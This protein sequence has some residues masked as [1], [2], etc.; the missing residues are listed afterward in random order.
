MPTYEYRCLDCGKTFEVVE[1]IE[2]HQ[3]AHR[4]CPECG[5]AHVEQVF[6]PFF[7]KT[8]KKS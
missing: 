1:H 6:S 3:Q 7:A 8:G 5:G 2:E 4:P